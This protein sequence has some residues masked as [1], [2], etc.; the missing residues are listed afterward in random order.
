MVNFFGHSH[1][2]WKARLE[3]QVALLIL[4]LELEISW[5]GRKS[6]HQNSEKNVTFV[7]NCLVKLPHSVSY[8]YASAQ[9]FL[10]HFKE[11]EYFINCT[12]LSCTL[13]LAITFK[14]F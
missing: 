8:N 9:Y 14:K 7:M 6:I 1:K 12:E 4:S 5:G 13:S 2:K 3:T 11:L 10:I